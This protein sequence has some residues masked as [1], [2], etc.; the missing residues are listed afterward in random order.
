[1]HALLAGHLIIN[2]VYI[3]ELNRSDDYLASL[4]DND[5]DPSHLAVDILDYMRDNRPLE[6]HAQVSHKLEKVSAL[7]FIFQI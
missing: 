3:L 4:T 1:M 5:V 7:S 2:G 6:D